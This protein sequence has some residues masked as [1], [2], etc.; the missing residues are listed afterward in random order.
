MGDDIQFGWEEEE[1]N[2]GQKEMEPSTEKRQW[3]WNEEFA[4]T[5]EQ[6]VESSI[7]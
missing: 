5:N 3:V 1:N 6:G 2:S 7:D 4:F